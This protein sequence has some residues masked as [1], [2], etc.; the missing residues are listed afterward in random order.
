MFHVVEL[1]CAP[2]LPHVAVLALISIGFAGCSADMSTRLSQ[3]FFPILLPRN[4]KPRLRSP[5]RSSAAN[6]RSMR[7]RK[8]T[9]HISRLPCRR[10]PSRRRNP[11]RHQ[12][13]GVG[14]GA[15]GLSSY[16]PPAQP[17]LETTGRCRSVRSLR[18]VVA[19]RAVP[20]SS[21]ARAIRSIPCRATTTSRPPRSCRPTVTRDRAPCRQASN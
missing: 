21:S 18:L 20:R 15:R 5:P 9:P 16:A 12:Q 19:R 2:R 14:R 7:G 17:Q 10:L 11:I 4:P 13:W 6:F 1:L 8:P 3:D